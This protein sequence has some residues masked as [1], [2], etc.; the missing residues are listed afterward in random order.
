[1]LRDNRREFVAGEASLR[2][3]IAGTGVSG[4]A[5]VRGD[6]NRQVCCAVEV[7]ILT[8]RI[9]GQLI[10][11]LRRSKI[12]TFMLVSESPAILPESI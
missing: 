12:A 7:G 3:R 10:V 8:L 2:S 1:M 6:C 9:F 4:A 5:L 11:S